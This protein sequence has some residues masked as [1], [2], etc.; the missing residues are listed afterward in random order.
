MSL[1]TRILLVFILIASLGWR[2]LFEPVIDRVERQYLE[3]AEEPMVETAEIFAA[4]VSQSLD[5]DG[6]LP[7]HLSEA[8]EQVRERELEARIYNLLKTE[9]DMEVTVTDTKGIVLFSSA[10][11]DQIGSDISRFNDISRTLAGRYGA[12]STRMDPEDEST[13]VMH[14]GAPI[15]IDG[16][17]HGVVSVAKPQASMFAFIRE[18][19]AL[20]RSIALAGVIGFL[21]IGILLSRWV[22][23]PLRKLTRHAEAV[24]KGSRQPTP[25]LP[26]RHLRILGESMEGMRDA[27]ED[28]NYVESY[29]QTLTHEMKGP[30]AAIRGAAEIM[31]GNPPEEQ[32]RTFAR[33]M[34]A[35]S[36]RLQRL[37]DRLLALAELENRKRLETPQRL[38]LSQLTSAIVDECRTKSP[39]SNYT[40]HFAAPEEAWVFGEEFLI[41]TAIRNL[42]GNALEFVPADHGQIEVTLSQQGNAFCLEIR[43][44]GPGLPDYA[45]DKVFDHFYSLPRPSSGHKSSGLGLCFVRECAHLHGGSAD[46][47]NHAEGGAI[48]TLTLP[49]TS[50][51]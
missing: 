43:D 24:A 15:L 44:N 17:I 19:K 49:S 3:A 11:A 14:V 37:L 45:K 7:A 36:E 28:R 41:K 5:K 32:R 48:A 6:A 34:L 4:L 46:L 18:T 23:H 51:S 33:N 16:T 40:I 12:R 47:A 10:S 27:L 25:K 39:N 1:T 35:E 38:N 50:D 29:V 20:L 42:L 9:V 30:V 13:S 2:F 26:G 8:F 22:S 31:D 21:I